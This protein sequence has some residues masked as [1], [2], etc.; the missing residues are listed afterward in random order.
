M[1]KIVLFLIL[2]LSGSIVSQDSEEFNICQNKAKNIKCSLNGKCTLVDGDNYICE[3]KEEFTTYPADNEVMCNYKKK[4]QLKA[5][6]LEFFLTYGS[7]HF[8]TKNYK[9]AIPKFI[10][11]F[12]LYY[13]F[14]ALRIVT[15][16][17]EENKKAN[18]LISIS[19]AVCFMGMISWQIYDLIKIGRGKYEDGNGVELKGW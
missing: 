4:S 11:F 15:K 7:A 13:I 8:Y 16:A 2:F 9:Y 18:F 3:C 10:V 14:I 19:A 6:L 1:S 12:L 17:K 5:F